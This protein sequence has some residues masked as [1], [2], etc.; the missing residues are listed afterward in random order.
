MS[1]D[2]LI[3]LG[4]ST[5]E[6]ITGILEM[7]APGQVAPGGVTVVSDPFELVPAPAVAS[8]VS[9]VDGVTCGNVF[10][11]TLDGAR[12]LA[13]AMIGGDEPGDQA[14]SELS[15]LEL[16]AVAEATNQMMSSAAIATSAV[17]GTEVE[18]GAPTTRTFLAPTD[19]RDVYPATPHAVRAE[20]SV[21]GRP[22]S[23][24]QL[25]PSAF[26]VR[27]TRAL[28][29]LDAEIVAAEPALSRPPA[30]PAPNGGPSLAGIPVRVWAEL[31][32]A[33]MPSARVVAMPAGAVVELNRSADEAIDVYV[34]G[35]RFASGRLVVVDGTDWAV[36]IEEIHAS[37]DP[38][39]GRWP[40][41]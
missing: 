19:A 17:L 20:L 36:R 11:M 13:A 25:I 10:V 26:V 40:A 24:V 6:A 28:D 16:S 1:D 41:S 30:V 15:E 34:N 38:E 21:C 35:T 29:E 2:A 5:L 9:Y 4:R 31:G 14:A 3:R 22:C 8:S 23:L 32:R 33:R 7:H 37:V 39:A 12:R 27:M 18:I